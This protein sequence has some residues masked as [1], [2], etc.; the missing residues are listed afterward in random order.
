M[1]ASEL[2]WKDTLAVAQSRFESVMID[3]KQYFVFFHANSDVDEYHTNYMTAVKRLNAESS[4]VNALSSL[5]SKRIKEMATQSEEIQQKAA[6]LKRETGKMD[7][8]YAQIT[9]TKAGADTRLED[10][11]DEYRS[12]FFANVRIA[13]SIGV[14]LWGWNK[15]AV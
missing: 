12:Q 8:A 7:A 1:S 4:G 10:T 2:N 6:Q 13:L 15:I 11:S 14:L 5:L 9:G 3:F